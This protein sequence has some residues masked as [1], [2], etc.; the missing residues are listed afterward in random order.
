MHSNFPISANVSLLKLLHGP[1]V[2]WFPDT[3]LADF[4]LDGI[5]LFRMLNYPDTGSRCVSS[6]LSTMEASRLDP[7]G[8]KNRAK[9]ARHQESPQIIRVDGWKKGS[10]RRGLDRS[11]TLFIR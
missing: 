5:A 8:G 10:G 4:L 1:F 7:P 11:T 9:H 6:A 3:D 2:F